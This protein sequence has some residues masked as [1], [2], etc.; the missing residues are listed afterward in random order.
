VLE[1]ANEEFEVCVAGHIM[2]IRSC[3]MS[4]TVGDAFLSAE[5]K[6]QLRDSV[7]LH[8]LFRIIRAAHSMLTGPLHIQGT[9]W[10]RHTWLSLF[11]TSSFGDCE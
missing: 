11:C 1:A 2:A 4:N 10:M 6:Y 3:T 7:Y 8:G 9:V 5:Q